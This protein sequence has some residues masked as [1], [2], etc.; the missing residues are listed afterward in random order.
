MWRTSDWNALKNPHGSTVL[1][2]IKT[3]NTFDQ[4]NPKHLS[5]YAKFVQNQHDKFDAL[6]PKTRGK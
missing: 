4:A 3:I 1:S 6:N 2:F 5:E